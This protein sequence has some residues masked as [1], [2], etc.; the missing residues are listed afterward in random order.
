[1]TLRIISAALL[2]VVKGIG[3]PF[4]E[5]AVFGESVDGP[6]ELLSCLAGAN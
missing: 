5:E 3:M 2:R 1:M 4:R 6:S